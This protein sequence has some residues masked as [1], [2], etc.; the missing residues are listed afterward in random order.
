MAENYRNAPDWVVWKPLDVQSSGT[1]VF[2]IYWGCETLVKK[3]EAGDWYIAGRVTSGYTVELPF[4]RL[5]N[6]SL[7]EL[8]DAF[9][10]TE[11]S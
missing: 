10:L 6:A 9:F 4:D 8:T 11:G 5:E 2:D 3:N 7:E 1:D